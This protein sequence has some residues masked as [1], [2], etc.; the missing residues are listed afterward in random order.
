MLTR[1]VGLRGTP[2]GDAAC[3]AGGPRQL[4]AFI[5]RTYRSLPPRP[6]D[7]RVF[8][9]LELSHHAP[10]GVR[11]YAVNPVASGGGFHFGYDGTVAVTL[12]DEPN[13][14]A[15]NL[16]C[17]NGSQLFTRHYLVDMLPRSD[18]LSEEEHFVASGRQVFPFVWMSNLEPGDFLGVTHAPLSC[19]PL[20]A[21]QHGGRPSGPPS[22][23]PGVTLVSAVSATPPAAVA[24]TASPS[25]ALLEHL[26][27]DQRASFLHVWE[28][29]P[30]HLHAVAFGL[31]GPGWTPF[32]IE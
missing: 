14:L 22:D 29:P 10:A 28:R 6:S 16:V 27:P 1:S 8:G 19:V 24:A 21:L 23:P 26:T 12:S 4:D 17:S 31:H 9:E 13:L 20:D 25:P 11:A 32:A 7:R 2:L 18:L 30:S 15:V 3:Y 5:T